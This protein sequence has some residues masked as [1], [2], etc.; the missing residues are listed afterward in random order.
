MKW[1]NSVGPDETTHFGSNMFAFVSVCRAKLIKLKYIKICTHKKCHAS[2]I[3][4]RESGISLPC[5]TLPSGEIMYLI[6][7]APSEYSALP[8]H[9]R[10]IISLWRTFFG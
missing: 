9:P 2:L 7:P 3:L 6:A 5:N 8:V 1:A 4:L 10:S